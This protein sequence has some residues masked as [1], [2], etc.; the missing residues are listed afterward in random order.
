MARRGRFPVSNRR[1][2][3]WENGP[4]ISNLTVTASGQIIGT[5]LTALADG[6]TLVRLR[7]LITL[8]LSVVGAALDGFSGAFGI[9]IVSSDAFDASAVMDPLTE[10]EWDGWIWH[11]F[12][13]LK[14]T[15]AGVGN[16]TSI[17]ERH[18]VIDSKAMRKMPADN[19]LM[20]A[21]EHTLVGTSTMQV[22]ANSRALFKLP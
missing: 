8:R 13:F 9:A 21:S 3:G 5:G 6:F 20:I 4:S 22:E 2:T 11:E 12:F 1:R 17:L 15:I 14:G 19:V 16:N 7:G 10:A 18:I